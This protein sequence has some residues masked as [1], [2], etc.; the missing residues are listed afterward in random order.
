ML[1][2]D[3]DLVTVLEGVDLAT[4]LVACS[5]LEDVGISFFLKG[6]GVQDLF[7]GG[8][9]GV[10]FNPV[11][12]PSKLQVRRDDEP[13]ARA[14]LAVSPEAILPDAELAALAESAREP[15]AEPPRFSGLDGLLSMLG[16]VIVGFGVWTGW[17][18]SELV[19]SWNSKAWRD[20]VSPDGPYYH[21]FWVSYR[22]GWLVTDS[23]L[24]L[25]SGLVL[26]LFWHR[27]RWFPIAMSTFLVT[28]VIVESLD[29]FVLWQILSAASMGAES[30]RSL[31]VIGGLTLFWVPYL[32]LSERVRAVFVE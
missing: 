17:G 1:S 32:R 26:I 12:G 11:T 13:R 7:A 20:F 15:V 24:F 3:A 16:L 29:L 6:E 2:R 9:L 5:R 31:V 22:A 25:W 28:N 19:N 4:M 21:P 8:R 27:K 30:F 14:A 23:V 18:L 10:G